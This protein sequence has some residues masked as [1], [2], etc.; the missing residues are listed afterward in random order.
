[1]NISMPVK[2]LEYIKCYMSH[3]LRPM[4]SHM[5]LI[6]K[7]CSLMEIRKQGLIP[8]RIDQQKAYYTQ[9][10]CNQVGVKVETQKNFT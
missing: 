6:M 5:H 4:K 1:M 9:I 3:S 2:N 7:V 8:F 10:L